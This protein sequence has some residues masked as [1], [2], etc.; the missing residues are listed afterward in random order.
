M[1]VKEFFMKKTT[2]FLG[3]LCFLIAGL[4]AQNAESIIRESRLA[5]SV[6]SMFMQARMLN[7]T[8]SGVDLERVFDWY[9]QDDQTGSRMLFVFQ[10]PASIANIRF[11]S[12]EDTDGQRDYYVSIPSMSRI[13]HISSSDEGGRFMGTDFSYSDLSFMGRSPGLDTHHLLREENVDGRPCFV[14]ES[15]PKDVSYQYSRTLQWIDKRNNVIRKAEFYDSRNALV[16]RLEVTESQTFNS[17]LYPKTITMTRI[18]ENTTTTIMIDDINFDE[19]ISQ[20]VF[21][22]E[23]L[24]SS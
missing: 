2:L 9:S 15:T 3:I 16:K 5:M 17:R 24:S 22:V 20:D 14:I 11:L 1:I 21:S 19:K 23:N 6:D 12:I 13:R 10:R 18:S 8:H 7:T 4:G